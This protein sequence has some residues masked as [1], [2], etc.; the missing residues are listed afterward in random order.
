MLP[1][2][3]PDPEFPFPLLFPELKFPLSF[4]V[5]PF[6]LKLP[7]F[8]FP[9]PLPVPAATKAGD[10]TAATHARQKPRYPR[11]ILRDSL[12]L[13]MAALLLQLLSLS[14]RRGE[15]GSGAFARAR[16]NFERRHGARHDNIA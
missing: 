8:P 4:P 14:L 9:F 13:T 1:L 12:F 5:F 10:D 7:T 6:P 16:L 15:A 11:P 3:R 2:P